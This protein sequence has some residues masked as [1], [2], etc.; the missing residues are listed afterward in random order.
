MPGLKKKGSCKNHQ[1]LKRQE[2]GLVTVD[3]FN[4]QTALMRSE[5]K[6]RE[7]EQLDQANVALDEDNKMATPINIQLPDVIPE[8]DIEATQT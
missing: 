8:E 7:Q 5:R 4:S 6:S 3:D 2:S 1:A